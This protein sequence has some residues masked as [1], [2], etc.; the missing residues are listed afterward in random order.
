MSALDTGLIKKISAAE[1]VMAWEQA[2][3]I[4]EKA[5]G[6]LEHAR[7][8]LEGAF[9]KD[10]YMYTIPNNNSGVEGLRKDNRK[11]AW[12]Q[13]IAL[14]EIRK[15][16]SN[17]RLE[18]LDK[19]IEHGEMPE[20][21]LDNILQISRGLVDSASEFA[22]EAVAE[23]FDFLRPGAGEYNKYKTNAKNARFELGKKVIIVRAV[24]WRYGGGYQINYWRRDN[25]RAVD[26]VFHLA[27]GAGQLKGYEGP[28]VDAIQ[29]ATSETNY[30]GETEYFR[31][32]CY[33]NG[34]LHLEFKR[35][36]LVTKLNATAGAGGNKLK[37]R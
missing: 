8:I 23:V 15:V 17:K 30:M 28:L 5:Y 24:E 37:G 13:I 26:R 2:T 12:R 31:F 7:E 33:V 18:E 14:L 9:G 27:D 6:D 20:I 25:I 4:M 3:V 11:R 32:K 34:N 21:N 36:D 35:P 16:M 29:T 1:I 10:A 19:N 22:V